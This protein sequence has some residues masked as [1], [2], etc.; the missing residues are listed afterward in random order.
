MNGL[1]SGA[2]KAENEEMDIDKKRNFVN[3]INKFDYFTHFLN[4]LSTPNRIRP[5]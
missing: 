1:G 2:R 4:L 5:L 3:L